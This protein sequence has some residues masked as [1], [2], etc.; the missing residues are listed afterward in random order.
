MLNICLPLDWAIKGI[1]NEYHIKYD[2]KDSLFFLL[3]QFYDIEI[4][5]FV[6]ELENDEKPTLSKRKS[7]SI[8]F[9][10]SINTL[11]D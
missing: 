3:K 10:L 5:S 6:Q 9:I 11:D 7:S 4:D 8:D 1:E 2:V